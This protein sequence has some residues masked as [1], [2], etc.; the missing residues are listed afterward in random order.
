MRWTRIT[1]ALPLVLIVGGCTPDA[2]PT[3]PGVSAP[4]AERGGL[5]HYDATAALNAV[6][7]GNQHAYDVSPSLVPPGA[8]LAPFVEA[9]LYAI[10]YIAMHDAL[11]AINPRFERYADNGP[12]DRSANPAVAVLTAAHDASLVESLA[13]YLQHA[14]WHCLTH[15]AIRC[16]IVAQKLQFEAKALCCVRGLRLDPLDDLR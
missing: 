13:N 8:P 1:A 5:T 10:T 9:R 4:L 2:A 15:A 12:L 3:D 6:N 14:E 16:L 11:N 7:A